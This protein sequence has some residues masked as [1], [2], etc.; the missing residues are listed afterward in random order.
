MSNTLTSP[1]EAASPPPRYSSF[2]S[3]HR[4]KTGSSSCVRK[5]VGERPSLFQSCFLGLLHAIGESQKTRLKIP[6]VQVRYLDE[7]DVNKSS[8]PPSKNTSLHVSKLATGKV[9]QIGKLSNIYP[10][11]TV[12]H[13]DFSKRQNPLLK[14]GRSFRAYI[15]ARR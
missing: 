9:I 12:K 14:L 1:L 10:Y 3:R 2:L 5:S 4:N 8:I 7:T 13:V 15:S 11:S 6:T